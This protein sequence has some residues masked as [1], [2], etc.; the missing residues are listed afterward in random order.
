MKRCDAPVA[1]HWPSAWN[2]LLPG[3]AT[4]HTLA[5]DEAEAPAPPRGTIAPGAKRKGM[6]CGG[7]RERRHTAASAGG[8]LSTWSR[9]S[10]RL[11][12]DLDDDA[13]AELDRIAAVEKARPEQYAASLLTELVR[14][15]ALDSP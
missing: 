8:H 12:L 2:L 3:G 10:R 11:S 1:V 6:P 7:G 14:G 5:P 13:G 15:R 4:L 9:M